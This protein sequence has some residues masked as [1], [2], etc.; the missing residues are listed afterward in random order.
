MAPVEEAK[1]ETVSIGGSDVAK[2][3]TLSDEVS[4][5]LRALVRSRLERDDCS[6]GAV[7]HSVGCAAV[8]D[9][10]ALLNGT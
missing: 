10:A 8:S 2:V 5:H 6:L 9:N 3:A 1:V 4:D 7:L